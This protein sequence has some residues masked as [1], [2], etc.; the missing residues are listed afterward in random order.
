MFRVVEPAST[1]PKCVKY[2]K[3][4]DEDDDDDVSVSRAGQASPKMGHTRGKGSLQRLLFMI[5]ELWFVQTN[6]YM[7]SSP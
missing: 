3:N 6:S 4:L 2:D 5:G 7:T 1:W